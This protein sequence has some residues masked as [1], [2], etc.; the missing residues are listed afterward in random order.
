MDERAETAGRFQ[1]ASRDRVVVPADILENHHP[2]PEAE[3]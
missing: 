1:H 3:S 2:D